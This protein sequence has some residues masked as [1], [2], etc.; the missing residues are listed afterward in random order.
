MNIN[1]FHGSCINVIHQRVLDNCRRF[2][3]N[4][5]DILKSIHNILRVMS[6]VEINGVSN[7]ETWAQDTEQRQTT[8]IKTKQK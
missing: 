2:I 6:L 7:T 8:N 5:N 1:E 3:E 4:Y